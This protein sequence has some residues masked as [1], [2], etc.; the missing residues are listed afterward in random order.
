MLYEV[1]TDITIIEPDPRSISYQP[2]LTLV[3]S[4]LW[5][6]EDV[7]YKRDDFLPKGVKLIEDSAA[8]FDPKNNT[9]TTKGGL[10][11]SYDYLVV[12]TGMM[13]NF[14]AIKGLDGE[15]TTCR[16]TSYNVCYT[17]L[18]RSCGRFSMLHRF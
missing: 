9:L 15:I 14:A 7:L 1:I 18:L 3:G 6:P 12:A 16:I 17:K 5:K 2:G 4:G 11:I 13:L 8:T 10:E